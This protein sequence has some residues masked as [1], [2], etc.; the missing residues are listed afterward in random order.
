MCH[1]ICRL[2][3]TAIPRHPSHS[4]IDPP[5]QG[6]HCASCLHLSGWTNKR[7]K[8]ITNGTASNYTPSTITLYNT[9]PPQRELP[10]A[11]PK[12]VYMYIQELQPGPSVSPSPNRIKVPVSP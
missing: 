6:S 8:N 9:V 4:G 12:L 11:L 5:H 2:L 1:D 7:H 10:S 3:L